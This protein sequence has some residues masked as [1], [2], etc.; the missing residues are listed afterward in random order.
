VKLR[1][2]VLKRLKKL[3]ITIPPHKKMERGM[4]K[5]NSRKK[6]KNGQGHHISSFLDGQAK[7]V[8]SF[9]G[10]IGHFETP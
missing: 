6:R 3:Q 2:H 4:E 7:H 9:S 8:F 10:N 1:I 5:A